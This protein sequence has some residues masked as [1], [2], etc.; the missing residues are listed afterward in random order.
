M[1]TAPPDKTLNP[2]GIATPMRPRPFLLLLA[3][4]T[5]LLAAVLL[6]ALP[7][8]LADEGPGAQVVLVGSYDTADYARDVAMAGGYA[9]IA[10]GSGG[11]VVI[12]V[13][14]PVNP[15]L[16]GGYDT[17]NY[18]DGVAVAGDYA[19]VAGNSRLVVVDI[20]DPPKPT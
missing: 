17:S 6:L 13:S 2:P 9:Y 3:G 5:M 12:N 16:A 7:G 10:Y 15:A 8:A 11:L 14:D 20:S 1:T 19:Y 4:V 18:A